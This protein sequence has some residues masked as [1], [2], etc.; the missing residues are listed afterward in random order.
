[1]EGGVVGAEGL[2]GRRSQGLRG[3]VRIPVLGGF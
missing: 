2:V 1:M 3:M